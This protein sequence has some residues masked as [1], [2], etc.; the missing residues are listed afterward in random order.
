MLVRSNA[1]SDR[2]GTSLM[3]VLISILIMGI[4]VTSVIALFP[5]GVERVRQA[6]LDTRCTIEALNAKETTKLKQ[7]PDDPALWRRDLYDGTDSTYDTEINNRYAFLVNTGELQDRYIPGQ[8][9]EYPDPGGG[10]TPLTY[11]PDNP[12]DAMKSY[13]IL[14]DPW[15]EYSGITE[16][17]INGTTSA[18]YNIRVATLAEAI[19][20][21]TTP[22]P[23]LFD[24][25]KAYLT[26]WF[27][28]AADLHFDPVNPVLPLNPRATD[29]TVANVD[30]V[31]LDTAAP[32]P[33][34]A[35]VYPYTWALM[36]QADLSPDPESST[37]NQSTARPDPTTG[38]SG[39]IRY[40]CFYKRNLTAAP[41]IVEGCFFDGSTKVTLSWSTTTNTRP[42]IKRGTWLMEASITRDSTND[43]G[44]RVSGDYP[45]GAAQ[46]SYYRRGF[47]FYR[48]VDFSDPVVDVGG[49]RVNQEVQVH[50]APRGL[51]VRHTLGD[52]RLPDTYVA[53]S[54]PIMD[55]DGNPNTQL[56]EAVAPAVFYPVVILDGLQEVF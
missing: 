34:A 26:R 19:A 32:N 12:T 56:T 21:P 38:A 25:R 35:R 49:G 20:I 24:E 11:T 29:S 47:E 27:S 18:Y 48:V 1:L 41:A 37:L 28:S 33:T 36:I 10:T 7:I 2:R 52:L 5:I 4:G 23:A 31:R 39:T 17:N 44:N 8:S 3:E 15:L 46:R 9:T 14:V 43:A 54:W 22:P 40:L 50:Q 45:V 42:A 6:V 55:T 30:Y 16:L 51:P 13:P 53:P